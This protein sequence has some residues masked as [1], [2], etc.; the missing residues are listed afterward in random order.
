MK[1]I[2]DITQWIS[3]QNLSNTFIADPISNNSQDTFVSYVSV[4]SV[5]SRINELKQRQAV[6]FSCSVAYIT[7]DEPNECLV[8]H[9]DRFYKTPWEIKWLSEENRVKWVKTINNEY[10]LTYN[11]ENS[12]LGQIFETRLP[13]IKKIT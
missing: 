5:E 11:A 4:D 9:L 8:F 6:N 12:F 3:S 13:I 2:D 1:Q 7:H 10:V